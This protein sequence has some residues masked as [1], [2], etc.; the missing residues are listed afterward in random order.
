MQ[1]VGTAVEQP[2]T[3]VA[4]QIPGQIHN[5]VELVMPL[6]RPALGQGDSFGHV[7]RCAPTLLRRL[8]QVSYILPDYFLSF[9]Q[10]GAG[11]LRRGGIGVRSPQSIPISQVQIDALGLQ[12]QGIRVFTV[13]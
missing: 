10:T 4:G 2:E 6:V 1:D 3:V 7:R 13:L 11:D 9:G 8:V 5:L 12:L